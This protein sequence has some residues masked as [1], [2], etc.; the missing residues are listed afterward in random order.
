MRAKYETLPNYLAP[1]HGLR[2][3]VAEGT[4]L[5]SPAARSYTADRLSVIDSLGGK[6]YRPRLYLNTLSSQP[7]A[8][9]VAGEL[10]E[11]RDAAANLLNE[12]CRAEQ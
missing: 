8:F 12:L 4:N 3:A 6:A 2:D 10:R 7:L 1:T 5:M 9:S 11:Q